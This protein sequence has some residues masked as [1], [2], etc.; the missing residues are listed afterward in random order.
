M[1]RG[2]G[3]TKKIVRSL[4]IESEALFRGREGLSGGLIFTEE[5]AIMI[6]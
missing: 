3:S 2:P 1:D 5:K 6:L 4:I